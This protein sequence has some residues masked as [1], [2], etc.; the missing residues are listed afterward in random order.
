M[1]NCIECDK[2]AKWVR[3]TQ[4]AGDHPYCEEH[5][6]LESDFNDSDSSLYWKELKN[7]HIS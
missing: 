1:N 2:P 6:K 4:F 7:E 3:C 5:A